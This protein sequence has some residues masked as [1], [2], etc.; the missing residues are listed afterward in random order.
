MSIK[1]TA[2][3]A[4]LAA[5]GLPPEL[6]ELWSLIF[7]FEQ[8]SKENKGCNETVGTFARLTRARLIHARENLWRLEK[9]HA[10]RI[11]Q[12][13]GEAHRIYCTP[14]RFDPKLLSPSKRRHVVDSN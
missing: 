9:C 1:K 3:V 10:I 11:E 7:G 4:L 14:E 12:R 2:Y 8:Q 13:P 5:R 6:L